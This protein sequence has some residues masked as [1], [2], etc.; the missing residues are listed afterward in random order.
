MFAP[1]L[2]THPT[3]GTSPTSFLPTPTVKLA[4]GCVLKFILLI[5]GPAYPDGEP[6]RP[7]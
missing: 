2:L 6:P 1:G 5:A 7:D 4:A 3:L